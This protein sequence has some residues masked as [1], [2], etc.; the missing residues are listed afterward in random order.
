M[1][2]KQMKEILAA[3][4]M[5]KEKI[6]MVQTGRF[7]RYTPSEQQIKLA[8]SLGNQDRIQA[9]RRAESGVPRTAEL[10]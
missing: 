3:G 9:A 4:G 5:G 7:M 10:R 6:K 1:S 2:A 8:K